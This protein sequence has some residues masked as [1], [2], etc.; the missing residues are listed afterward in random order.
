LKGDKQEVLLSWFIGIPYTRTQKT[1]QVKCIFSIYSESL[2]AIF[3]WL[4]VGVLL[5]QARLE[6][7][8]YSVHFAQA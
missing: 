7:T 2:L 3:S 8:R 5:A 4:N 6:E 1:E